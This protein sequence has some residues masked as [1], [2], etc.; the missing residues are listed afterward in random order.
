[1][2]IITKKKY[3][4]SRFIKALQLLFAV[5]LLITFFSACDKDDDDVQPKPPSTSK[6][7][8]MPLG[9][10]R[11]EGAR[12]EFESYRYEL[13]KL[14]LDEKWDFDYVGT[15]T[16]NASYEDVSNSTF[17]KDHEGRGGWTS[18]EI[19]DGLSEWLS[20]VGSVDIVLFSSPGGNDI[21][22]GLSSYDETISNINA[23][24]D[25]LQSVNP[26]VTIII[27]QLAPGKSDFMTT[28]FKNNFNKI[29]EEVLTIATQQT[30]TTSQVLT[31]DMYT[32]FNDSYLADEVHYNEAGAK[33]IANRYLKVLREILER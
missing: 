16:D 23:I 21:L 3:K 31:V 12:P 10:S 9:A 30:T 8:I 25:T 11:V 33:F 1:M 32:G 26:N 15:Q 24:I 29:Q 18:G 17:D 4:T 6:N 19:L 5:I 13:W 27:E 20:N 14:L 28:E 22:N 2:S 7:R